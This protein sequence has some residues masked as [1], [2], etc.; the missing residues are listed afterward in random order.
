MTRERIYKAK[1]EFVNYAAM[2]AERSRYRNPGG[3]PVDQVGDHVLIDGEVSGVP[4]LESEG[5]A[6]ADPQREQVAVPIASESEV[7]LELDV[8]HPHQQHVQMEQGVV[9]EL[10]VRLLPVAEVSHGR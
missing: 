5:H 8:R 4:V 9:V 7:Q 3:R 6:A 2:A 10:N 1:S